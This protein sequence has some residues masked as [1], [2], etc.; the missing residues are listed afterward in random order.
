VAYRLT[1]ENW[2]RETY[3]YL[4]SLAQRTNPNLYFDVNN[5]DFLH[6]QLLRA[7]ARK[8]DDSMARK[9]WII[10]DAV[11]GDHVP[12]A[13]IMALFTIM[14]GQLII[15]DREFGVD[16][17]YSDAK[18]AFD[19]N[20][21][22]YENEELKGFVKKNP[23]PDEQFKETFGRPRRRNDGVLQPKQAWHYRDY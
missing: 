17:V 21:R 4:N 9:G 6:D 15:P 16:D 3:E 12:D 5:C 8:G 23:T 13:F 22:K 10:Q 19:Y 1:Q 14:S 2:R 7:Q 11:R 18:K 20:I